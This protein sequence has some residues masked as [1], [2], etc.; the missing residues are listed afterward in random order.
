MPQFRPRTI[1]TSAVRKP[2]IMPAMAPCLLARFQKMPMTSAG[3]KPEPAR[4][5]A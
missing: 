4:A 3:K 5:K 2:T 1:S